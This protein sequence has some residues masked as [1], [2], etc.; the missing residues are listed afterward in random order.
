M[1]F[2][3]RHEFQLTLNMKRDVLLD[4]IFFILQNASIFATIFKAYFQ[5]MKPTLYSTLLI[6]GVY[7][8]L[9]LV[10]CA[11]WTKKLTSLGSGWNFWFA[12]NTK[13][14]LIILCLKFVKNYNV[15]FN[16]NMGILK[17]LEQ[18][19]KCWY[20][21]KCFLCC[22]WISFPMPLHKNV[23]FWPSRG[24]E[25]SFSIEISSIDCP[26]ETKN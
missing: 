3:I 24:F 18:K 4:F 8:S 23:M 5:N 1:I 16:V 14:F 19:L 7:V 22:H 21:I 10:S 6:A 17:L 25:S 11:I 26:A 12:F 13:L 2:K 15:H 9:N 20:L